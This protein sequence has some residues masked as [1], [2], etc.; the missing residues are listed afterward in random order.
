M[1]AATPHGASASDSG[2]WKQHNIRRVASFLRSAIQSLQPASAFGRDRRR[3]WYRAK[4]LLS[5]SG[6]VSRNV[7]DEQRDDVLAGRIGTVAQ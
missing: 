1:L 7:E 2:P 4:E 5:R 6:R 3:V